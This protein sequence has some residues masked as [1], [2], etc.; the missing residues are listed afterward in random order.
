[1]RGIAAIAGI[2]Q[3]DFSKSSGRSELQ[4]AAEASLAALADAG[5]T[6]DDVDGMVTFTIDPTEDNELMRTLGVPTLSYTVRIPHGG[7]GSAV[8]VLAAA[9]AVAT[10]AARHVLVYRALNARSGN[11]FGR[12]RHPGSSPQRGTGWDFTHWLAPYGA[13]SPA[14]ILSLQTLPWMRARGLTNRDFADY[15]VGIRDFAASNPAAWFYKRPITVED[16]QASR[17]IV[18]PILRLFDC[19]QETDGGVALVVTTTERAR[20]LKQA[21]A[22]VL[23][24]V[25]GVGP[26]P[27][28]SGRVYAMAGV[29]P[30]DLDAA[31]IYD[32]FSPHVYM[33]LEAFSLCPEGDVKDFVA[34]GAIARGG[35]LPVNTNGGLIGEAYLHGMNLIT[36]AV[37][38]IRGTAVNQVEDAEV[39]SMSSGANVFILGRDRG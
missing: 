5:L 31:M 2:G 21:P 9:S 35:S 10:G 37:R 30:E 26:D 36:E 33:G 14:A 25:Q 8:T 19:C 1:M 34:S 29:G 13:L 18:E 23:G 16:H 27:G 20:D 7:G 24:A 11:R 28:T 38:Q 15:I 4:L 17:W 6:V 12:A 32:A 22:V 39:V 3:T